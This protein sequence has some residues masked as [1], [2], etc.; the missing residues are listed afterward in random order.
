MGFSV[1]LSEVAGTL[2]SH[3]WGTARVWLT[4]GWRSQAV[5]YRLPPMSSQALV[6][7]SY[8]LICLDYI[9]T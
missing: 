6:L 2:L 3:P 4:P 5:I 9:W 8:S 7:G 1:G